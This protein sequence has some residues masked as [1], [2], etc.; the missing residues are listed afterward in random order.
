MKQALQPGLAHQIK[1]MFPLAVAYFTS[2]GPLAS[3]RDDNLLSTDIDCVTKNEAALTTTIAAD[4][5][6]ER[7]LFE[8]LE[9]FRANDY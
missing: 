8:A 1:L 6:T 7:N 3:V 5:V 2:T 4:P 9:A